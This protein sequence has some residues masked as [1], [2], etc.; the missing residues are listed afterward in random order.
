[1][2]AFSCYFPQQLIFIVVLFYG[3]SIFIYASAEIVEPKLAYDL[4][5][6]WAIHMLKVNHNI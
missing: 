3:D 2:K 4:N 5:M 6:Y 1:M